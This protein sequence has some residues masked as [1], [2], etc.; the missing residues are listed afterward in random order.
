[1][2]CINI[3]VQ[4]I[5]LNGDSLSIVDLSY[6]SNYLD[7]TDEQDL[8]ISGD[9]LMIDNDDGVNALIQMNHLPSN[10]TSSKM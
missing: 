1:M 8:Y 3:G 7:N 4:N 5:V 2:G 6:L 9:S 10:D